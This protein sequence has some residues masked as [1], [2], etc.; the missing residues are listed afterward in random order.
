MRNYDLSL[1]LS[2][3]LS[4]TELPLKITEIKDFLSAFN[5]ENLLEA[6]LGRQR[7]SYPIKGQR[8]GYFVNFSFALSPESA[9]PLKNKLKLEPGVMRFMMLGKKAGEAIFTVESA[10]AVFEEAKAVS[11]GV[12]IEKKDKTTETSHVDLSDINK[13]IDEI[14]QKDD[15]VV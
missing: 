4:E 12:K 10:K 7:L 8:F 14:L 6:N 13:K 5:A 11:K 15:F 1:I 3:R 2:G 9:A